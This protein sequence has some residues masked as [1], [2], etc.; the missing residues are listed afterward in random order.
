MVLSAKQQWSL[1]IVHM[2]GLMRHTLYLGHNG[3]V[4]FWQGEKLVRL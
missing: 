2:K 4:G 3:S 1:P